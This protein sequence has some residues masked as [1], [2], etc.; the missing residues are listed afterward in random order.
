MK[1]LLV[2]DM[3]EDFI[4]GSLAVPNALE[5]ITPIVRRVA[6]EER[7]AVV[8]ATRDWHPAD[9]VSFA[10]EPT[11]VDGSWPAHCVQNTRGAEIDPTINALFDVL[12]T[13]GF[14]RT[15]EA[16]SAF[17]GEDEEGLSLDAV[18]RAFK[19]EEVDVVGLALDYCVRASALDAA[20]LGYRTSVWY[21]G[22]RPVHEGGGF[23]TLYE[24]VNDGVSILA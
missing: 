11:F 12:I 5:V 9:H 8:V 24:L 19:I 23:A 16:Y 22:T 7:Y 10:E 20:K 18:L 14:D 6:Y 21:P 15:R 13:K 2:I 1:A 3:Q 4:T 17:D